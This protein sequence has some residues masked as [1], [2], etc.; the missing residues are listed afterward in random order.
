MPKSTK[1]E[2]YRWIK[3]ILDKEMSIK[4]MAKVC[5]LSERSLKYWLSKFRKHGIDDLENKSRRP[6]TQPKET[7]IR[8][9]ERII[10]LRK[11]T[12]LCARKMKWKLEKENVVVQEKRF[13]NKTPALDG[14]ILTN[15]EMSV[16]ELKEFAKLSENVRRA[17]DEA[18]SR[19]NL[20]ARAYHRV[21]KLARTIADLEESD[22]IKE[23]HIFEAL[24]YRP[25]QT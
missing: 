20:S 5:P 7:P 21:I 1:E 25:K 16:R 18:A 15:S 2:K 6:K 22:K 13:K 12:K 17:L 19:L 14:Q 3:P 9:K 11:E 23:P 4:N 8:I 10:E 24:Q